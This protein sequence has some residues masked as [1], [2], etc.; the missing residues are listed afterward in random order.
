MRGPVG[1]RGGGAR[2]GGCGEAFS[3][4]TV[5]LPEDFQ[6]EVSSTPIALG[7]ECSGGARLEGL[8]NVSE[9]FFYAPENRHQ[10]FHCLKLAWKTSTHVS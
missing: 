7:A 3:F 4:P 5:R 10:C 9:P 6:V 1:G 8:D 2:E